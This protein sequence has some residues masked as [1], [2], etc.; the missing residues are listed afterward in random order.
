MASLI[1]GIPGLLYEQFVPPEERELRLRNPLP[2]AA[3][4]PGKYVQNLK[5]IPGMLEYPASFQEREERGMDPYQGPIAHILDTLP[6]AAWQAFPFLPIIKDASGQASQAISSL[7]ESIA[8]IFNTPEF[9]VEAGTVQPIVESALSMMAGGKGGRPKGGGIWPK[10]KQ[11][12]ELENVGRREDKA[13]RLVTPLGEADTPPEVP[14]STDSTEPTPY[15]S[16]I[17]RLDAELE[18][19]R[20][21]LRDYSDYQPHVPEQESYTSLPNV[22]NPDAVVRRAV[23]EY[24]WRSGGMRFR[25][26]GVRAYGGGPYDINKPLTKEARTRMEDDNVRIEENFKFWNDRVEKLEELASQLENAESGYR[27]GERKWMDRHGR[28]MFPFEDYTS[29]QDLFEIL[30]EKLFENLDVDAEKFFSRATPQEERDRIERIQAAEEGI[31]GK[32]HK[33]KTERPIQP[34]GGVQISD[35]EYTLGVRQIHFNKDGSLTDEGVKLLREHDIQVKTLAERNRTKISPDQAALGRFA[36]IKRREEEKI[37]HELGRIR[38]RERSWED[39]RG[40]FQTGRRLEEGQMEYERSDSAAEME[41]N[42]QES[43]ARDR[44]KREY[45]SNLAGGEEEAYMR[46]LQ[47]ESKRI[48]T[49]KITDDLDSAKIRGGSA[50]TKVGLEKGKSPPTWEHYWSNMFKTPDV[51]IEKLLENIDPEIIGS[52]AQAEGYNPRKKRELVDAVTDALMEEEIDFL[53]PFNLSNNTAT[54]PRF[55]YQYREYLIEGPQGGGITHHERA[56]DPTI[57]SYEKGEQLTGPLEE[58]QIQLKLDRLTDLSRRRYRMAAQNLLLEAGYITED[59]IRRA[60][61]D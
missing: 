33:F 36:E 29:P 9:A 58:S 14:K 61:E 37:L 18:A 44:E 40:I 50:G 20:I 45:Y 32:R 7:S 53:D 47:A 23:P 16:Y 43:L 46:Y 3:S 28:P 57:K 22:T 31:A 41:R 25:Q 49:G 2:Y 8:N 21:K 19:S 60:W 13:K 56:T 26:R 39:Y 15:T 4:L 30:F 11:G 54:F 24:D 55:L 59:D 17:D 35:D 38:Q 1:G 51:P 12:R 10:G 34:A 6:Q 52:K 42:Y 5:Q 27:S 48:K